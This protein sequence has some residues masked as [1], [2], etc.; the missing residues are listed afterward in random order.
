MNRNVRIRR[1]R[2]KGIWGV[3][4]HTDPSIPINRYRPDYRCSRVWM[5]LAPPEEGK[6]GK[7]GTPGYCCIVGELLNKNLLYEQGS[8]VLLDE[9]SSLDPA[10]FT[11]QEQL[12]Y[13]IT[14]LGHVQ[15]TLEDL[16]RGAIALKDLYE[17]ELCWCVPDSHF[18][19]YMRRTEGLTWYETNYRSSWRFRFPCLRKGYD[20][21]SSGPVVGLVG[22]AEEVRPENRDYGLQLVNT[23]FARNRIA[24]EGYLPDES[25]ESGQKEHMT[26]FQNQREIWPSINRA[27]S[28]VIAN[29]QERPVAQTVSSPQRRERGYI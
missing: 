3:F 26:L 8:Y 6:P 2:D 20:D 12:Q 23:L 18:L 14:S 5:G 15:P 29:M 22:E 25:V 1:N 11:E 17:P 7:D 16:R 24:V 19:D 27:L 9:A 13:Q 28:W 4:K 21:M 10:D